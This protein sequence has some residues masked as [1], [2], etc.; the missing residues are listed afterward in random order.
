ML[1]EYGATIK[2]ISV[3]LFKYV[4]PYHYSLLPSEAASNMARY[5]G[6]KFGQ[7]PREFET[8]HNQN[9]IEDP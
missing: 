3:P 6:I 4:L 5:E 1:E 2:V 7:T 8:S 9:V